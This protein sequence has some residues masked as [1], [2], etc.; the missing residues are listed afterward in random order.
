MGRQPVIVGTEAPEVDQS[1]DTGRLR[2]R[3]E[4]FRRQP[5]GPLE[6]DPTLMDRAFEVDTP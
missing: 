4:P 5:V 2:G 6:I 1:A 3:R